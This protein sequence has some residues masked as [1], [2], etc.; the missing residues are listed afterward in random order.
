MSSSGSDEREADLVARGRRPPLLRG[1]VR[2][3]RRRGS[4]ARTPAQEKRW[5][6]GI[7]ERR[8]A[9]S[10]TSSARHGR[11]ATSASRSGGSGGASRCTGCAA[12]LPGHSIRLARTSSR[13]R[14]CASRSV[15]RSDLTICGEDAAIA[16]ACSRARTPDMG[17]GR[18]TMVWFA[19]GR[20]RVCIPPGGTWYR[21]AMT[22]PRRAVPEPRRVQRHRALPDRVRDRRGA[23]HGHR[24]RAGVLRPRHDR[25][26]GRA[27][28]RLR[29]QLHERAA[30]ALRAWR[31]AR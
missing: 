5:T 21:E 31:S 19:T 6:S 15:A 4:T 1:E 7:R 9:R 23:R 26:G 12:V 3:A 17:A 24:H 30:A 11:S 29:L 10:G 18:R 25:P 13:W 8:S 14:R 16:V 28:V 22:T 27:R 20:W 2:R